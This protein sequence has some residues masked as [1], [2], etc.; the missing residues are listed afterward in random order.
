MIHG[1]VLHL[2]SIHQ[3][4]YLLI[5]VCLVWYQWILAI[6]SRV[7]SLRQPCQQNNLKEQ[8]IYK[9]HKTSIDSI[10][11]NPNQFSYFVIY[12]VYKLWNIRWICTYLYPFNT[13][14]R[15]SGQVTL[16]VFCFQNCCGA[17]SWNPTTKKLIIYLSY[18]VNMTTIDDMVWKEPSD[19]GALYDIN[20]S[21]L[22]KMAAISTFRNAVSSMKIFVF[23]FKFHWNMF[24]MFH[25]TI[26]KY[27]FR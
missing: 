18:V 24:A 20:S 5:A 4:I 27:W 2:Y 1:W 9:S 21:P 17:N 10:N 6:F 19:Q 11:G 26:I 12:A 13:T 23:W 25:L 22:D 8:W 15:K 14:K 3:E 16:P 7:I